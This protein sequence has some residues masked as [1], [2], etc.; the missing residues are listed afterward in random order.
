MQRVLGYTARLPNSLLSDDGI[1]PEYTCDNPLS[2]FQRSE[3]LRQAATRA[4]AAQ[5]SRTKILKVLRARHRPPA[6]VANGQII[7]VWRQAKSVTADGM[8]QE[9]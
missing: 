4:W 3:A 5:D 6:T 9:S 2:G 1:D 7:Y 8:D